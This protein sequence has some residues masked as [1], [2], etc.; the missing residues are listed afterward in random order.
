[1]GVVEILALCG[2]VLCIG[3]LLLLAFLNDKDIRK[4]SDRVQQ[5]EEQHA[6]FLSEQDS[7]KE[8]PSSQSSTEK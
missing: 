3:C 6:E 7:Q 8:N 2:I 5:L 4:L 1:M